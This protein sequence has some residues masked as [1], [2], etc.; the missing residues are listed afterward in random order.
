MKYTIVALILL[1]PLSASADMP[2]IESPVW[3]S[4]ESGVFSTG[5]VWH[6]VDLDGYLDLFIGNGNDMSQSPDYVY[7]N[8]LGVIPTSHTWSTGTTDYSGHCAVGDIDKDGYP[9]FVIANFIG[10]NWTATN[11]YIYDNV[12][13]TLTTPAIW[14]SPHQFY[15]FSCELGDV[16]GDGDLDLA[17]ACGDGYHETAERMRVYYNVS[18]AISTDSFWLSGIETYMLDVAWG[19]V[20]RDGDLDLAFCGDA[21]RVHLYENND[22]ELS[23]WPAWTSADENHSNTLAW[24]DVDNDGYLELAVADNNQLGGSGRF[25]FY[26]NNGGV[27]ATSPY[28]QSSS[29]GYG[30]SVCWYDFDRDGDNDLAT[31]RWWGEVTIYENIGGTLTTTPVWQSTNDFVVEE[32]RVCDIDNDGVEPEHTIRTDGLKVFYVDKYPMHWVDSVLVDGEKLTIDDYC[33]DL[34]SGWVSL[35]TAPTQKVECFYRYSDKQDIGAS[36][37]EGSNFIYAD[38]LTHVPPAFDRGDADGDGN[39]NVSD[40]VFLIDFVFDDGTAPFPLER[41]D[42]NCDDKCNVTDIV[43]LIAFIFGDGLPPCE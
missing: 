16:D 43:Y 18:G 26:K 42:V 4:S 22:G 11:S 6:D 10:P 36:N 17:F 14:T 38:T 30:S 9:E 25:K 27:L 34:N 31:G 41:G 5:L 23:I 15:S 32:I 2:Y 8:T 24:G 35:A 13:G 20:D 39:I 12:G 19:D 3:Q 29:G 33:Y 1:L 40:V 37:W 21:G 28:W 7:K